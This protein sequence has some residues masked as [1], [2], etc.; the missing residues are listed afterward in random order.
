MLIHERE[1]CSF[2]TKKSWQLIIKT[3]NNSQAEVIILDG[4]GS[5]YQDFGVILGS[6]WGRLEVILGRSW[7]HLWI[8]LGLLGSLR[9]H[10]G[11]MLGS[12]W[13]R[14]GITWGSFYFSVPGRPRGLDLIC[15]TLLA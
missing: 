4:L 1:S 12:L 13:V 2:F 8:I 7:C 9:G 6:F 10:F 5:R 3:H 14:L 15:V 11:V